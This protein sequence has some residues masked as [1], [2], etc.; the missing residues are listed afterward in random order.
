M[1][2]LTQSEEERIEN[3]FCITP[4][5]YHYSIKGYVYCIDCMHGKSSE[6]GTEDI[7]LKK[8]WDRER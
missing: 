3:F 8:R 7:E 1:T 2:P 6:M 5:C 4:D